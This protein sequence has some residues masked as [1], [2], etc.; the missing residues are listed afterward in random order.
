MIVRRRHKVLVQGMTGKQGT[1]WTEKMI[2]CGTQVVGGVNPKRA[3]ET[4]LD[5]PVFA[6]AKEAMRSAPFEMTPSPKR[7][8]VASSKS[9]PGVRMVIATVRVSPPRS[10]RISRGSSPATASIRSTSSPPSGVSTRTRST[11]PRRPSSLIR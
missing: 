3:G 2:A 1:F 11:A 8:P 7:N 6:T 5:L 4:Y 9:L 10:N